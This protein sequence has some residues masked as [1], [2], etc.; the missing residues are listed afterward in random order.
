MILPFQIVRA[1]N[2]NI[3]SE[4][5]ILY[6]LNDLD[7]LYELDSNEK[8]QIASL[9]KIMTT[10]V[11]IEHIENLDEEVTV[12]KEAFQGIREYTQVGLKTGNVVT[13][14]DLLY[15]TMLPSG[16]DAVNAMAI[17]LAGS[18]EGFVELMNKKVEEL[19]LENTHFDNPI[20]MD[21]DNNY[22]TASDIAKLLLYSLE[23]E[24]FKTIFTAREYTIPKL[25]IPMKTTLIGY[26]KS[27]G[28]DIT[29]ITGAKSGF[30][31]GAGLCLA[32]TASIDDVNY[33]LV[34]IGADTKN[35]S[36]AVRDSLNI[37]G[38]YSST[39]SYQKVIKKEQLLTSIDIKWGKEKKYDV[40]SKEDILVYLENNMYRNKIEYV[41]D[42]IEGIT[43]QNHKGD[44]IGT[45]TVVYDGED[46]TT[47]DVYLEEELEFYYPVLYAVI[48]ISFITMMLS[49]RKIICRKKRKKDK[50]LKNGK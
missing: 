50:K 45:V 16:A 41:Y 27:Y 14:R 35:R 26:S 38:Y 3:T 5:V 10:I 42:G 29:D 48:V 8:T 30:T 22:S 12:T 44:K 11:A 46:I 47:Y 32:S 15:G 34:T 39:Y 33:L 36:N 25:N 1:E 24:T 37:Y 43:Y 18:V 40:V 13:Y 23:N 28:L 17:G 9:T 49:L 2:F 7:V 31:D 21:S 6:N 4:H 20:G 19:G